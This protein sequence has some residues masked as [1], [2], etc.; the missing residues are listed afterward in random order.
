MSSDSSI[1]AII[2]SRIKPH[3]KKTILG[4][5]D[6]KKILYS[7]T[8]SQFH[9]IELA[10]SASK[11]DI[12]MAVGGDGTINEVING[13]DLNRQ[14]VLPVP[15]GTWNGIAYQ[16]G[17]R[18]VTDALDLVDNHDVFTIDLMDAEVTCSQLTMFNRMF[19][20]FASI[21]QDGRVT[22]IARKFRSLPAHLRY[23]IGGVIATLTIKKVSAEIQINSIKKD[24]RK[25]SSCLVNNGAANFFATVKHWDMQDGTGEL[26]I[27][28]HSLVTQFVWNF[29]CLSPY[30]GAYV[31]QIENLSI[32]LS[33]PLPLMIDGELFPDVS[34]FSMNIR[35]RALHLI[36]PKTA[37]LKR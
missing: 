1:F 17:I 19:L 2:N 35:P 23:L 9:A 6:S 14:S 22:M 4:F 20:G 28:S 33:K 34:S 7:E 32:K 25:I 27:G 5:L 10:R 3:I 8:K 26:Q 12:V 11:Y 31:K 36:L 24:T 18:S 37:L 30:S 15:A 16:I 29:L 13:I 21:G